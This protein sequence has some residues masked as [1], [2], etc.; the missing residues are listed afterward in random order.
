LRGDSGFGAALALALGKP[1]AAVGDDEGAQENWET[2]VEMM[3]P[4]EFI[5]LIRGKGSFDTC[6]EKE[7]RDTLTLQRTL[8]C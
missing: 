6:S 7:M 8:K 3:M 2:G 1:P 4:V 5:S